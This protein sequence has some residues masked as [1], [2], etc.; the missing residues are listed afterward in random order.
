[1]LSSIFGSVD[2]FQPLKRVLSPHEE[3]SMASL[4]QNPPHV[5]GI[6]ERHNVNLRQ[7]RQ[8]SAKVAA[9]AAVLGAFLAIPFL[10]GHPKHEQAPKPSQDTSSQP[11]HSPLQV[12]RVEGKSQQTGQGL[13]VG[14]GS[15]SGLGQSGSGQ[16][17]T[18][19]PNQGGLTNPPTNPPGGQPAD[20]SKSQGHQYGRSYL[21][22]PKEHG[23]HDLGL[24]KGEDKGNA[25]A[26][27]YQGNHPEDLG[28]RH[29]EG[30]GG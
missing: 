24:H 3:A 22:P 11:S 19:G 27:G 20:G 12:E 7:V 25:Q 9:A 4:H 26:P 18:P 8:K 23:Y 1:M 30:N 17:Q 5:R 21:A 2:K 28:V 10:I 13:G 29:Q 14:S 6:F 15:V 16:N